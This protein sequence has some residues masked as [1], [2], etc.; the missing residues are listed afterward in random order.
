MIPWGKM[1]NMGQEPF[2]FD[3][4]FSVLDMLYD[5]IASVYTDDLGFSKHQQH[6]LKLHQ[7]LSLV[8]IH[9]YPRLS[10]MMWTNSLGNLIYHRYMT[11]SWSTLYPT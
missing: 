1:S 4:F 5:K 9:I 7:S 10:F 2:L 8:P 3:V 11:L 6:Y